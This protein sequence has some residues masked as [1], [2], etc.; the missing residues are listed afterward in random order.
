MK[1]ERVDNYVK[2]HGAD[3]GKAEQREAI[4][5]GKEIYQGNITLKDAGDA[6]IRAVK[7][8]REDG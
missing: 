5:I 2:K 4:R 3:L 8:K 1:D 7:G 6:A